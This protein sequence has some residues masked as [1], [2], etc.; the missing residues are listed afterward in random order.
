MTTIAIN[1]A[2]ERPFITADRL[3]TSA[4][5]KLRVRY[6]DQKL[7]LSKNGCFAY[8]WAGFDMH[9]SAID[10][11]E[12]LLEWMLRNGE[13]YFDQNTV[14]AKRASNFFATRSSEILVLSK[15]KAIQIDRGVY[16][17]IERM[18]AFGTGAMSMMAL[19]TYTKDMK[20][21]CEKM[22]VLDHMSGSDKPT[23]DIIYQDTLKDFPVEKAK[24]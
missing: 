6:F 13:E 15:D 18:S 11:D 16:S 10:E 17:I 20:L 23:F 21:I 5:G 2:N 24:Q 3:V 22:R 14:S 1:L 12:A 9:S 7:R 4:A 19:M 8:A